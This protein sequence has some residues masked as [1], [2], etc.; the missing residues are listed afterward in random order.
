MGSKI[1]N[2]IDQYVNDQRATWRGRPE[3]L[4][5]LTTTEGGYIVWFYAEKGEARLAVG[6]RRFTL[7]EAQL[8]WEESA[9]VYGEWSRYGTVS[10]HFTVRAARARD[11]ESRVLPKARRLA[12]RLGLRHTQY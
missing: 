6:C 3:G 8:H 9:R 4:R 7:K 1:E 11:M 12:N 2:Y 5:K 10:S